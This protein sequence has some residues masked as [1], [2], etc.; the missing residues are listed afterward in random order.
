MSHLGYE[1]R[2]SRGPW[3][4]CGKLRANLQFYKHYRYRLLYVLTSG[5]I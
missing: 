1:S 3:V 5:P 2:E 4:T